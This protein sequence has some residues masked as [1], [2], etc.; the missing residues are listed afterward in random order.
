M[1]PSQCNSTRMIAVLKELFAEHEIPEVIR[2][3]NGPQFASHLFVGFTKDWNIDHTQSSPRNPRSN[4]QA[5]SAVKIVK[6]LLN[7]PSSQDRTRTLLYS[8][9]GVHLLTPTCDPLQRCSTNV[10]S[11]PQCHRGSGTRTPELN[12]TENDSMTEPPR[13]LHTTTVTPGPSHHSMLDKQSQCSMMPRPFGYPPP[14]SDK[15]PMD[16][17][18]LKSL[19]EDVTDEPVTTSV[20]DTQMP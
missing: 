20:S 8:P 14:S 19:E 11:R 10:P 13:V 3:D 15:Q 17:T 18:W 12:R 9:T 7:E 2:T 16:P 6:G 1:S 5:E 4:G